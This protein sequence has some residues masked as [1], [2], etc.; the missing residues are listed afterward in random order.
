MQPDLSDLTTTL[1]ATSGLPSLAWSILAYT[2]LLAF[3]AIAIL[4]TG[5]W[6]WRQI[7]QAWGDLRER[8]AQINLH[9]ESRLHCDRSTN[10][11]DV[12]HAFAD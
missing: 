3:A 11:S 9:C 2:L 7:I 4:T 12:R 1:A 10:P 6:A 5:Y 8:R